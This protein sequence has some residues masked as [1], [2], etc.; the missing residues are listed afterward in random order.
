LSALSSKI[1]IRSNLDKRAAGRLMFL[2][3]VSFLLYLPYKG[4]AAAKIDVLALSVVTIPAL[5]IETVCCY[6][7]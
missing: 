3:G 4:F 5:A 1:K 2:W 7:T 6:M